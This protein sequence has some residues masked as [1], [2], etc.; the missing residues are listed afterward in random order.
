[1]DV[2]ILGG[3]YDEA[4]SPLSATVLAS[5][6]G[7]EFAAAFAAGQALAPARVP[8]PAAL[9]GLSLTT[10]CLMRRRRRKP[11]TPLRSRGLAVDALPARG[12]GRRGAPFRRAILDTALPAMRRCIS[13]RGRLRESLSHLR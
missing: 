8:E 10:L 1:T 13:I 9:A 5:E 11:L 2:T 6:F 7:S 12:E 3:F 4:A